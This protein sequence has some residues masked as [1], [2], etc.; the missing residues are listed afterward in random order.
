[1]SDIEHDRMVLIHYER[2]IATFSNKLSRRVI[3][4]KQ[5][6]NTLELLFC[7]MVNLKVT[8][9]PTEDYSASY[10]IAL[11]TGGTVEPEAFSYKEKLTDKMS[12]DR[13]IYFLNQYCYPDGVFED[14]GDKY[15]ISEEG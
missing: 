13:L 15:L 2:D 12:I 1:M 7:N 4:A 8:F 9:H 11:L 6:E 10:T 3:R 5:V 14:I